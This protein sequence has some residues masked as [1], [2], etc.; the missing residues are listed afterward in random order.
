MATAPAPPYEEKR[1]GVRDRRMSD[2]IGVLTFFGTGRI[3]PH[4]RY[5]LKD[6]L[7]VHLYV[8]EGGR[9][10]VAEPVTGAFTSDDD[11]GRAVAGFIGAF[12]EEFEFLCQQESSLSPALASDLK[13]F[14]MLIEAPSQ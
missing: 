7:T 13:R 10:V 2:S 1:K 9:F 8:D 4:T 12:V 6:N 11:L 14:R 3:L 5:T